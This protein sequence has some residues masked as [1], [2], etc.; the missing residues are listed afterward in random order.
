MIRKIVRRQALRPIV[1]KSTASFRERP[2][3]ASSQTSPDQ[4]P[5]P[6]LAADP[7]PVR[8]A[9]AQLAAYVAALAVVVPVE[10]ARFHRA[11]S[12]AGGAAGWLLNI[13]LDTTLPL[14]LLVMAPPL[15]W[16]RTSRHGRRHEGGQRWRAQTS[17]S[18]VVWAK[19]VV[20]QRCRAWMLAG[21][22]GLTSWMV[23]AGIANMHVGGVH[24]VRFGELP[25]AYHDEYSYLFQARTFLAGRLSFPS[26][27][28]APGL[29]N[30]VHVL[31]EGRFASRYFPGVGAWLAPFVAIGKPYWGQ[32]LAGALTCVFMFWTGR[33]LGGDGIGFTAGLLTAVSPGMGLFS[34]LLL[35]HHATCLGLSLFCFAFVRLMRTKRRR[36]GVWA[37]IGLSFAMLCRPLTA[38]AVGL[39]FGIWLFWWLAR[40]CASNPIRSVRFRLQVVSAVGTPVLAGLLVMGLYDRAITGSVWTTPYQLYTDLYTPRHVYGF[41]NVRRGEQRL[42]PHVLDNYDRWAEN[43]T[44]SLAVRNVKNRLIASSQ[45]TL[46]I[47]PLLMGSV[48]FLLLL[49]GK[50][51]RWRLIPVA[52]VVLHLAYVPYWFDGIMHWHYVFESGPLLVLMFAG[53]SAWLVSGWRRTG[54]VVM[55]FWWGAIIV[56]ALLT[57]YTS[58]DSIWPISRLRAG[59]EEVAFSRRKYAAFNRLVEQSVTER[60]ALVLIDPDPADRHIDYVVNSPD[61]T[62][63]VLFGRMPRDQEKLQEILQ[64][65]PRRTF[66]VYDVR[67]HRFKRIS[68][69]ALPT[70]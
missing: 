1:H 33:E 67:R 13:N 21:M 63:D 61:L 56:A 38:A 39:P 14:L 70:P 42:G 51:S 32:W 65:F 10:V 57:N 53:A 8:F 17:G 62:A 35:S 54:R 3:S 11:A 40:G 49:P 2:I 18:T 60:P 50:D 28:Q 68:R 58:C 59:V 22:V 6:S 31:N 4:L 27:S 36:D 20:S 15:W 47:V 66:Y 16:Y 45:W 37:G 46:G 30:Q 43:L 44:P 25:P 9:V 41:N 48:A 69:N 26:H 52:V 12:S 24:V 7:A 29:F 5:E 55:P 19:N 23:S 34:N 64:L